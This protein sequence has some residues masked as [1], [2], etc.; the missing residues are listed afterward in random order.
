[1]FRGLVVIYGE[2]MGGDGLVALGTGSEKRHGVTMST[3][4]EM[5]G[6]FVQIITEG[7]MMGKEVCVRS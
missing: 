2:H 3:R 6:E 4:C 5:R 7:E 1:V